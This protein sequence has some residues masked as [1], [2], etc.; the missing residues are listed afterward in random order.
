MADLEFEKTVTSKVT[1]RMSVFDE[2]TDHDRM[3]AK[4][5]LF[6]SDDGG[7]FQMVHLEKGIALASV[8]IR[9]VNS[10]ETLKAFMSYEAYRHEQSPAIF[11]SNDDAV[12]AIFIDYVNWTFIGIVFD[13]KIYQLYRSY[14]NGKSNQGHTIN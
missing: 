11:N 7:L 6:Q 14:Y 10:E 13:A 4:A 3:Y 1:I 9:T 2:N 8:E 5:V 12:E